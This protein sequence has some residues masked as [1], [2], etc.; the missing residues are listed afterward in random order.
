VIGAAIGA[1]IMSSISRLLVFLGFSSEYDNTITGILLI[2]IV[3]LDS[4]LRQRNVENARRER[5]IAR[6][7]SKKEIRKGHSQE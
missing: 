5:L 4:L 3:V 6:S 2:T 1:V 7:C